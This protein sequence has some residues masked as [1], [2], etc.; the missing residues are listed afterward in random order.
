M[1]TTPHTDWREEAREIISRAILD[2]QNQIH[3]LR[4]LQATAAEIDDRMVASLNYHYE[5]LEILITQALASREEEIR[6][7][8]KES[9]N[10]SEVRGIE[11]NWAIAHFENAMQI[12]TPKTD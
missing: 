3:D 10:S 4:S 2:G 7:V 12:L 9:I 5:K 11:K 8:F 6:R 1:T